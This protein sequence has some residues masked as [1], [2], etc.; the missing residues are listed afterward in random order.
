MIANPLNKGLAS[1]LVNG[2]VVSIGV[3]SSFNLFGYSGSICLCLLDGPF[4]VV[5]NACMFET[6]H[7][8]FK[9][10]MVV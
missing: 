2:H 7:A 1:K 10:I 9:H 3:L 5:I 6:C 8:L 4:W